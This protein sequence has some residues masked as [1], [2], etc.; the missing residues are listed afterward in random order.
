[1]HITEFDFLIIILF[2]LTLPVILWNLHFSLKPFLRLFRYFFSI[3]KAKTQSSFKSFLF[4]LKQ[5]FKKRFSL[6]CILID[7][8]E[9]KSQ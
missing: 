8:R 7:V 1:M 2:I 4:A 6:A 3:K 9:L 5:T